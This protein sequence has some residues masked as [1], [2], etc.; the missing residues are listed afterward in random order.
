MI[1]L[2]DYR[3]DSSRLIYMKNDK[4]GSKTHVSDC[5]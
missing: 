4:E 2:E 1:R 3:K 5:D